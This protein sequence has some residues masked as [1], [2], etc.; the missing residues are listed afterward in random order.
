MKILL[1]D[2]NISSLSDRQLQKLGYSVKHLPAGVSDNYILKEARRIRCV[3]VT[4]DAD[5]LR[6]SPKDTGGIVVLRIPAPNVR[7]M[8]TAI[9]RLER[10]FNFRKWKSKILLVEE[11]G[12]IIF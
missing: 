1:L 7:A 6:L 3:I 8:T 9:E 4:R 10:Q 11:Q 2:E 12:F 5:F